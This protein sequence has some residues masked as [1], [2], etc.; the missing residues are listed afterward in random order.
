MGGV[1]PLSA[2]PAQFVA[3]TTV[4]YT[5]SSSE[6]PATDGWSLSVYLAGPA[7]LAKAAT[8]SGADYAVTLTATD[9]ALAPG[10]YTWSEQ[11]T[12]A[13]V[14][15]EIGSGTV[16]VLAN[17]ALAVGASQ[18]AWEEKTLAVVEAALSGQLTTGMASY[19]IAG[20][21]VSKIPIADLRALR[22]DLRAALARR[23]RGGSAMQTFGVRF[24][25]AN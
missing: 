16:S 21:A 20:R 8:A 6:Y 7:A 4:S 17:P 19:Q 12:K 11:V 22:A 9:T 23:R 14:V 5:R 25:G 24:T 3:G 18:Q 10:L 13:G 1:S 2:M 15:Q